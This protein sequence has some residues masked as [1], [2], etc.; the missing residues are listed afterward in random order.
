MEYKKNNMIKHL[1]I[2]QN[3]SFV[4]NSMQFIEKK[5]YFERDILYWLIRVIINWNI[6]TEDFSQTYNTI[7]KKKYSAFII[8]KQNKILKKKESYPL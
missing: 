7:T 6:A 8:E 5:T 3:N 4:D 1:K 2:A